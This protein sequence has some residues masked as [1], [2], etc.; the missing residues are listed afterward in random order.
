MVFL[1]DLGRHLAQ[2]TGEVRSTPYLLQRISVA[3]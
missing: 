2:V 1:R 3:V